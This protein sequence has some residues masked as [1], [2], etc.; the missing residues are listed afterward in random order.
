MEPRK[1]ITYS[2]RNM[3]QEI[4]KIVLREQGRLKANR[5]TSQFGIDQTIYSII[6]EWEKCK[7]DKK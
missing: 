6:R 5:G 7:E 4:Y 2:F 1:K 3:P